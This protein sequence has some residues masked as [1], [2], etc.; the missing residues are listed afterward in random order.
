MEAAVALRDN[1]TGA[2]GCICSRGMFRKVVILKRIWKRPTLKWVICRTGAELLQQ[3]RSFD[4]V[5]LI[6]LIYDRKKKIMTARSNL[7]FYGRWRMNSAKGK[8][9]NN[10]AWLM[11]ARLARDARNVTKKKKNDWSCS[12]M[13]NCSSK[14]EMHPSILYH[15]VW[16]MRWCHH[17]QKYEH[18]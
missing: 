5:S 17:C 7:K 6:N 4:F 1:R 10:E 9:K 2:F 13:T 16:S 18:V 8:K 3:S 12:A 15:C 11:S 14:P